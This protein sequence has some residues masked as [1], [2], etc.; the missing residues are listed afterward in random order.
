MLAFLLLLLT[1]SVSTSSVGTFWAINDIHYDPFYNTGSDESKSCHTGIGNA[2]PYGSISC[3]APK[4]LVDS[5][6]DFMAK[7]H[8]NPDFVAFLGD[9]IAHE[10][11]GYDRHEISKLLK[12]ITSDIK[13]RFNAPLLPMIG[14]HDF[15]PLFQLGPLNRWIYSDSYDIWSDIIPQKQIYLKGGYY[16]IDF[17]SKLTFIVLNTNLY[18]KLNLESLPFKD[19]EGQ[20]KWLG[21]QLKRL[22]TE[23][24]YAMVFM[25]VPIGVIECWPTPLGNMHK[26]FNTRLIELIRTATSHGR[27]GSMFAGHEHSSTL[28]LVMKDEKPGTVQFISPSL[29]Y[30]KSFP[31]GGN[32]A[33]VR[34]YRYNKT[35]GIVLDYDQYYLNVTEANSN[36]KADWKLEHSGKK[37][38]G[39]SDFS[40]KSVFSIYNSL[41]RDTKL[42][43]SFIRM[44]SVGLD[45]SPIKPITK[46]RHLCAL[47]WA[48]LD[49][50]NRCIIES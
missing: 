25:H 33:A 37:F 27:V 17:N 21:Q 11:G 40:A 18:Y 41:S 14:N 23:D 50:Y 32:H 49:D 15:L 19:P 24:R 16:S 3:S 48:L 34:L 26:G 42:L 4:L 5:A 44:N 28:R 9:V 45:E 47:R 10:I 29:V 13:S 22:E 38:F 12:G 43:N 2:G 31:Y 8:P 6:L 39:V 7:K 1:V 35:T 30:S 46:K 36:G 20:F